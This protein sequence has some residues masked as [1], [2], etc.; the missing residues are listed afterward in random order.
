[1]LAVAVLGAVALALGAC[2]GGDGSKDEGGLDFVEPVE[3]SDRAREDLGAALDALPRATGLSDADKT[4]SLLG[5][6]DVF[7]LWF[8]VKEDGSVSRSETWY[9]LD[10][11]VSYEFLDGTL[12]FAV[13]MDEIGEL[14]LVPLQ[15]D[16][17]AFDQSTTLDDVREMLDDP[18]ELTP[19][20]AREEYELEVTVWA[21]EQLMAAFD[22]D[23]ALLY[24]ETVALE[25]AGLP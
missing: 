20:E 9:Y 3:L 13:P 4:H 8:E 18:D 7:Q 1:M 21:G 19:E 15:Y 6:P 5:A 22:R 17:L 10:L 16:P 2:G 14:M 25:L 23:G 12:L 11:E 24:V